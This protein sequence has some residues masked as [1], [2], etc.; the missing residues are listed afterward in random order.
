M[1]YSK[2]VNLIILA[3]GS[4]KITIGKDLE[5][6]KMFPTAFVLGI[7]KDGSPNIHYT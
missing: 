4:N 3:W 6:I 2:K 1:D 7:N 5:V